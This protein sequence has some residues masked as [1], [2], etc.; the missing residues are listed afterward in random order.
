MNAKRSVGCLAVALILIGLVIIIGSGM[1]KMD[2]YDA[3]V[4]IVGFIMTAVIIG[5]IVA[6]IYLLY[7][8]VKAN[9][10]RTKTTQMDCPACGESIEINA[11]YC[12][13]CGAKL[14]YNCPS[15]NADVKFESEFCLSVELS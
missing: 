1:S 9:E 8:I 3:G 13:K 2:P 6:I 15:C 5:V 14:L 10:N 12:P 7:R 11:K 4:A